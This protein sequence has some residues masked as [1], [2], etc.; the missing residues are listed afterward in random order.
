MLNT[1]VPSSDASTIQ[2]CAPIHT[3]RPSEC[4]PWTQ[5]PA[6]HTLVAR[7]PRRI[8]GLS[9]HAPTYRSLGHSRRKAFI[10]NQTA[11]SYKARRT[12]SYDHNG[13]VTMQ[14]LVSEPKRGH[15]RLKHF[16]R[17]N[18]HIHSNQTT[19]TQIHLTLELST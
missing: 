6:P 10:G 4:R 14:F 8:S 2:H 13:E 16:L 11:L 17:M 3:P 5:N 15:K 1:E 9:R 7:S 12:Q 19:L 18:H